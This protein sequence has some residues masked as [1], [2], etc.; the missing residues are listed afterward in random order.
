MPVKLDSLTAGQNIRCTVNAVPAAQGHIDTIFR[1]MRQ[2]ETVKKALKKSQR[3]R[4]QTM[5]V[6]N[7]GNRD[8]TSREKVGKIV[9]VEPGRSWTMPFF[10]QLAPDIRAV[11]KYLSIEAA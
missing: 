7:R 9:E 10:F 3:R 5:N 4:R 1:L 8:W 6:Y 2:D 11:E